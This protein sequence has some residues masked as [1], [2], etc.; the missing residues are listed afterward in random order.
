[1]DESQVDIV[2][3]EEGKTGFLG[4]GAKDT[5]IQ[6]T[7]KI[8]S[9]DVEDKSGK[10]LSSVKTKAKI[11]LV[12]EQKD[13][14]HISYDSKN[15]SVDGDQRALDLEPLSDVT[16]LADD[17]A[18]FQERAKEVLQTI[19]TQMGIEAEVVIRSGDDLVDED[20]N[21]PLTLNVTGADLGV[22]I[23][24]RGETL[25]SLQFVV[26]QILNKEAGQWVPIIIDVE[27]YL[28]RRRKKLQQLAFRMAD[29]VAFSKRKI[30]LEPMTSQERRIIH[31]Q[32][33]GHEQ[34][35]TRSAGEGNRR[36]V[37][38]LPK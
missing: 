17:Q 37:I 10:I 36:K 18:G 33:R 29:K 22:L 34:V 4:L 32:L 26:R 24:H 38:I 14:N 23:G 7:P 1:M 3:L 11:G 31:M 19:L 20:E 27:S 16:N 5:I 30:T 2:V 9:N 12:N 13:H 8:I 6:I 25:Q 35:Y 28:V 15:V 21:P